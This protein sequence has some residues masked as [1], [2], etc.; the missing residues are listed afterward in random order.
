MVGCDGSQAT[1]H[2]QCRDLVAL[3]VVFL[4]RNARSI[5]LFCYNCL[6]RCVSLCLFLDLTMAT[7][8]RDLGEGPEGGQL[9]PDDI[10]AL[11]WDT[12]TEALRASDSTVHSS[13]L[14]RPMV[15]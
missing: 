5:Q 14:E 7:P 10:R 2:A 13:P 4:C 12:V 6:P 9:T 1:T 11:V 3:R 8:E 15:Q